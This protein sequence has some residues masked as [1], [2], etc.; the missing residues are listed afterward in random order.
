MMGER[1]K[2]DMKETLDK[3]VAIQAPEELPADV[4]LLRSEVTRL[5]KNLRREQAKTEVLLQAARETLSPLR[6][7]G[8]VKPYS[9]DKG[10]RRKQ[11]TL[12][13]VISDTQVGK[14][15][16]SYNFDIFQ[17]R[18]NRYF[19]RL[20]RLTELQRSHHPVHDL[21]VICD[22]DLVEGEGIFAGQAWEVQ[23]GALEQAT[24]FAQVVS[25]AILKISSHYRSVSVHVI[26]GNH[27]RTG[28]DW[29]PKSNFDLIAGELLKHLC[30]TVQNVS[31]EVCYEWFKLVEVANTRILVTH[32]DKIRSGGDTPVTAIVKR[33]SRWRDSIKPEWQVLILGHF[34]NYVNLHW[35]GAELFVNGSTEDGNEYARGYLGMASDPLQV[36][37]FVHPDKGVTARYPIKLRDVQ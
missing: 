15:T 18:I 33:I 1:S 28:K 17:A 36:C 14:V 24:R 13:A 37:F 22:G 5:S 10:D 2:D 34:H 6:V 7:S 19:E 8:I 26:G 3:R 27:G 16:E 25:T 11:E 29:N 30:A 12:V 31:V 9:A 21:V 35:N 20:L 32:G 4:E 23:A